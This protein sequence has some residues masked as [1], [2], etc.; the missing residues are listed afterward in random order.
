MKKILSTILLL[1]LAS[2]IMQ[3]Q[4]LKEKREGNHIGFI[5]EQGK[6][7][8]PIIYD[9]ILDPYDEAII[10]QKGNK[11]GLLSRENK[12]I[13]PLEYDGFYYGYGNI[14]F[15]KNNKYGLFD[16]H[17]RNLIPC[18]Y[19]EIRP[20]KFGTNCYVVARDGRYGLIDSHNNVLVDFKYDEL[21]FVGK[22][23][24]SVKD[25]DTS[26][27]GLIDLSEKEIFP[28]QYLQ[29]KPSL[30]QDAF[31][32]V[33]ESFAKGIITAQG[34]IIIPIEKGDIETLDDDTYLVEQEWNSSLYGVIDTLGNLIVP[35]EYTKIE[36]LKNGLR[37]VSKDK[38]H[39]GFINTENKVIIPFEYTSYGFTSPELM[40]LQRVSDNK[41]IIVDNKGNRLIKHDYDSYDYN[42]D[43]KQI[44]LEHDRKFGMV[45][46]DGLTPVLPFEYDY[47]EYGENKAIIAKKNGKWGYINNQAKEII[48]LIYEDAIILSRESRAFLKNGK[49]C[50][51]DNSG[52]V[53]SS[54]KYD[55]IISDEFPQTHI[56]RKGKLYGIIDPWGSLMEDFK[57]EKISRN[58]HADYLVSLNGKWGLITMPLFGGGRLEHIIPCKYDSINE[59]IGNENLFNGFLVKE[60]GKWGL[61]NTSGD[62]MLPCI[63]DE[64]T[65]GEDESGI[66]SNTKKFSLR[67]GTVW[68]TKEIEIN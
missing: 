24:L 12:V 36:E 58:S 37:R 2:T 18:E 6:V 32:V 29:I 1:L 31:I 25:P 57:Y 8:I 49:W 3:A 48:P 7:I 41:W 55:E 64:I 14:W 42:F 68:E 23:H 50:V 47:L 20:D 15:S 11:S 17:G 13:L 63:Y 52:K 61:L 44:I 26:L 67:K 66:F 22:R 34:K 9:M 28:K 21:D 51:I 65:I 4:A 43:T 27:Y 10:V 40:I 16:K 5:N 53:T 39:F 38:T 56:V 30:N 33:E 54:M 45:N 46:K 62:E 35:Y 19:D 59:N 60:N